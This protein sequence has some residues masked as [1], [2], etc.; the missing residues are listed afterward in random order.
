MAALAHSRERWRI[1]CGDLQETCQA[2]A[3]DASG[4]AP[5][6]VVRAKRSNRD[7]PVAKPAAGSGLPLTRGRVTVA[8]LARKGE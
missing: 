3:T 6:A 5:E 2:S 4:G 1:T 8:L 7:R